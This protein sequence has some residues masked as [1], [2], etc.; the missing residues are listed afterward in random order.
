[1]KVS[2]KQLKVVLTSRIKMIDLAFLDLNL[3]KFL[4]FNDFFSDLASF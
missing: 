4:H 1:M 2:Y 3:G